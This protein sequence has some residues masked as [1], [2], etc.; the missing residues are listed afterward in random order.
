VDSFVFITSPLSPLPYGYSDVPVHINQYSAHYDS[1]HFDEEFH[2][3]FMAWP[4]DFP[5]AIL[6]A[7]LVGVGTYEDAD[8]V[9]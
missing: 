1:V 6:N 7:N 2:L 9:L 5:N 4:M 8:A 3:I